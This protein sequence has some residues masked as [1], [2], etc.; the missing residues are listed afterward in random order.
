MA[1]PQWLKDVISFINGFRKFTVMVL[2][3]VT[4]ISFRVTDFITGSEFVELLRYTTV[5]YMGTNALEHM[6]KA[7]VEWVK[8]K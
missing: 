2:L 3:L 8:K 6:S 5:A 7:V 1:M 4:G